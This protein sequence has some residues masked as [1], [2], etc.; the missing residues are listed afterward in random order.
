MIDPTLAISKFEQLAWLAATAESEIDRAALYGGTMALFMALREEN[1]ELKL[2]LERSL[3]SLRWSI[4]AMLGYDRADGHEKD[5][6][7]IWALGQ[8]AVM[9]RELGLGSNGAA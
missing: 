2:G 1:A 4:C 6:Q 9:R 3:E 8:I 5:S 7:L